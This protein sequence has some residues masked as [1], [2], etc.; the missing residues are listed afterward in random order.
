MLILTIRTDNPQTEIGLY[1]DQK[2]LD[3]LSYTA[4]RILAETIHLKIKE[5]LDNNK[6]AFK[7]IEG[8]VCYKGPGSFTGLRIGLSV[9]NSLAYGLSVPII[10]A[11]T[12]NWLIIG[13]DALT[14]GQNDQR[15]MPEY[16]AEP[17]I[18]VPKK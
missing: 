15:V 2:K 16:G 17:H 7:N 3:Y 18:T 13:L 4:H 9:A 1:D 12:D 14:N 11:E 6:L 10:G 5:V 8:I